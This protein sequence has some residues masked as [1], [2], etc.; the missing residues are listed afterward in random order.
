MITIVVLVYLFLSTKGSF[1]E[2]LPSYGN[3]SQ[4]RQYS[5]PHIQLTSHLL[6]IA[7]SQPHI[8]STL[9][10]VNLTLIKT[11]F[12][13]ASHLPDLTFTQPRSCSTPFVF[14]LTCFQHHFHSASHFNLAMVF[15]KSWL[16]WNDSMKVRFAC[17]AGRRVT[18]TR[19]G[20]EVTLCIGTVASG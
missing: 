5:Q 10:F 16:Q 18:C 19:N 14:N 7:F 1:R 6:H 2:E 9:H 8:F 11:H 4:D 12:H 3:R 20:S 13:S 15:C 17:S